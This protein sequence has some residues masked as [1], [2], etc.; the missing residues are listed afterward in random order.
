VLELAFGIACDIHPVNNM[1]VLQYLQREFGVSDAQKQS[2]Y[3]HWV[4]EGLRATEQLLK[5]YGS[6]RF[7][8][9]EQPTLADCCLVPQV[10]N[11]LRMGCQ[12]DEFSLVNSIY[13][14]CMDLSVFQAAAPINQPD[15]AS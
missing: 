13:K 9:G 2:W 11:A 4:S 15:F 8:F 3:D 12:I 7:C 1:R 10:F 14:H 5:Q 6:G